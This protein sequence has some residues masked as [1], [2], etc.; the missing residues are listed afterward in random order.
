MVSKHKHHSAEQHGP[1]VGLHHVG[2]ERVG[3]SGYKIV[4]N[5]FPSHKHHKHECECGY[6]NVAHTFEI[7]RAGTIN[8]QHIECQHHKSIIFRAG[9]YQSEQQDYAGPNKV[10]PCICPWVVVVIRHQQI[11]HSTAHTSQTAIVDMEDSHIV[12]VGGDDEKCQ[13]RQENTHLFQHP[14][15]VGCEL[16][17]NGITC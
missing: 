5:F 7:D 3:I 16:R 2:V 12:D 8:K 4:F 10:R 15:L 11:N 13:K 6:D 14:L 17:R 9:A 1:G